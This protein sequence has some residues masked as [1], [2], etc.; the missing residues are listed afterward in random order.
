MINKGT[1][2]KMKLTSVKITAIAMLL[3]SMPALAVDEPPPAPE[4]STID[5]IV[6]LALGGTKQSPP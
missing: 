3:V 5:I 2:V 6:A 4:Q 1:P